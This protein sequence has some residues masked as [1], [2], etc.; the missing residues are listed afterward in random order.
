MFSLKREFNTTFIIRFIKIEKEES[1]Y[2]LFF[3][4]F[5]PGL[6]LAREWPPLELTVSHKS[7]KSGDRGADEAKLRELVVK[8][9]HTRARARVFARP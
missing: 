7:Y 4:S 5:P 8:W 6:N 9:L 1:C 2:A 3:Q